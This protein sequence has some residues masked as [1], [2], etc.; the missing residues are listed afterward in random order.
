NSR[1]TS[2][3]RLRRVHGPGC[4]A[5]PARRRG[6]SRLRGAAGLGPYHPRHQDYRRIASEWATEGR[7]H[8][9][10]LYYSQGSPAQVSDWVRRLFELYSVD[11]LRN[12]TLG[13]PVD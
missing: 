9:G 6:S 4:W 1:S 12:V 7:T 11:D 8:T 13:L 3:R 10:I 2:V 5:P